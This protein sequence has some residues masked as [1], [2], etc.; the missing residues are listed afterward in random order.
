MVALSGTVL[1]VYQICAA[2]YDILLFSKAD[3]CIFPN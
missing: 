2:E 3:I 1:V